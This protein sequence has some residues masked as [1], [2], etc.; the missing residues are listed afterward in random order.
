MKY[1]SIQLCLCGAVGRMLAYQTEGQE[2]CSPCEGYHKA[3]IMSNKRD[4]ILISG[5]YFGTSA[6]TIV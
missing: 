6:I 2:L 1:K 5:L 3:T 4:F